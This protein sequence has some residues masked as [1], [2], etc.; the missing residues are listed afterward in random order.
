MPI[1]QLID[2]DWFSF[3]ICFIF[4]QDL[5]KHGLFMHQIMMKTE[6]KLQHVQYFFTTVIDKS[7]RTWAHDFIEPSPNGK[8]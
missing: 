8:E 6:I 5:Q 4:S 1:N 3:F 2:I 7:W